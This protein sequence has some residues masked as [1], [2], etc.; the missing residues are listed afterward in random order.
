[1]IDNLSSLSLSEE[2]LIRDP[3]DN[4]IYQRYPNVDEVWYDGVGNVTHRRYSTGN[5]AFWAY[6]STNSVVYYRDNKGNEK[7]FDKGGNRIHDNN[8][9]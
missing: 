4:L 9:C 1:M 5:E 2:V 6:N 8:K 7:W 3:S